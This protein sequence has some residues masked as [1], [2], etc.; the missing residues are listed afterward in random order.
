MPAKV[1]TAGFAPH[2]LHRLRDRL[3]ELFCQYHHPKYLESDPLQFLHR[4]PN[5]ADQEVVGLIAALLAYGRVNTIFSSVQKVLSLLGPRPQQAI[6]QIEPCKIREQLKDFK[7]RFNTAEDV[8]ALLTCLQQILRKHGS[9][10]AAYRSGYRKSDPDTFRAS[11]RFMTLFN[12]CL[13]Q[14]TAANETLSYG[15]KFLL[16]SPANGG[17]CKRLNLFVR[18]MARPKD[19]LDLG[20]WNQICPSKL[21]IPLDTHIHQIGRFLGLTHRASGDWKTAVQITESLRRI[22]PKDPVRFDFALSRLGILEACE[23]RRLL[24]KCSQC[25]LDSICSAP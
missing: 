12:R 7:H 11:S 3:E 20:L 1:A 18:W 9:L 19:G 23:G 16:A 24:S 10:Q 25:S 6:L 22:D 13:S 17:A 14:S 5:P 21:I 2:S 15:L 4:Y 8:V